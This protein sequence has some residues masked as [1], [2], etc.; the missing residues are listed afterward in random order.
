[1]SLKK[2]EDYRENL[3]FFKNPFML[4]EL[5]FC[6]TPGVRYRAA[7]VCPQSLW[8]S[9]ALG[10]AGVLPAADSLSLEFWGL[11]ERVQMWEHLEGLRRLPLRLLLVVP[12][13]VFAIAGLLLFC[14]FA[15]LLVGDILAMETGLASKKPDA[16]IRGLCHLSPLTFFFYYLLLGSW[17]GMGENKGWNDGRW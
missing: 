2:K 9:C 12:A 10:G 4:C 15:G 14:C 5:C 16:L 8:S 1:M 13:A 17:K 6:L 3:G 7:S 11:F